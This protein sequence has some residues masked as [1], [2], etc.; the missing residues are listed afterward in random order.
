M[1]QCQPVSCIPA[2]F[3]LQMDDSEN[4]AHFKTEDNHIEDR[5][6]LP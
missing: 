2:Q 4:K 5:Q 3:S 6:E 1:R